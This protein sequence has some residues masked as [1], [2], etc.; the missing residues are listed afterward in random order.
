MQDQFID[1]LGNLMDENY[2]NPE[3]SVE[4]LSSGLGLSRSQLHRK[5]TAL[6]NESATKFIRTYRLKKAKILLNA[7]SASISEI[8]YD[9]G[10]NNVSYFNKCFL[11]TFGSRPGD[12]V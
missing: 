8:A 10:F 3:Y 9:V 5:L 1:K 12:T 7:N 4:D 2:Q 6:T 11:E